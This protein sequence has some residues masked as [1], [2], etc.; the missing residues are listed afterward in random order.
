MWLGNMKCRV[1]RFVSGDDSPGSCSRCGAQLAPF[2]STGDE[3]SER[4]VKLAPVP[5][6]GAEPGER[7]R[8]E[9]ADGPSS[10]T[11]TTEEEGSLI[12]NARPLIN[13]SEITSECTSG[14]PPS[15][16]EKQEEEEEEGAS[17]PQGVT[18]PSDSSKTAPQCM[19]G[20][21]PKKS[22]KRKKKKNKG[23]KGPS[24]SGEQDSLPP[25]STAP[26]QMTELL[27]T[28]VIPQEIQTLGSEVAQ[29]GA[30]VLAGDSGGARESDGALGH[31]GKEAGSLE[32]VAEGSHGS[33]D[34][35]TPPKQ[36]STD[37]VA[38]PPPPSSAAPKEKVRGESTTVCGETVRRNVEG[39]SCSPGAGQ[40]PETRPDSQSS[41]S[42]KKL[43]STGE[44]GSVSSG[45]SPGTGVP[46][47]E[48]A[49]PGA[50]D[51]SQGAKTPPVVKSSQAGKDKQDARQKVS[52][53]TS[54]NEVTKEEKK[55]PSEKMHEVTEKASQTKGL[56]VALINTSEITSECTSGGPPSSTEKQEEEEEEGASL[57]QG[58]T[59]PSDSSKTAP[60]CMAGDSPKKSRKR[61]KKKNKGKKGP[62][63]SGEQDSLP[64]L[65]TA[66][67]QMTELLDTCVIPQEIQTLGSEVAQAGADVL[68]GD[69]GGAR[70]SDGAL[71]HLG[72]EAGSL[73]VVAEGSHGSVD[74]MTPP[75]QSSTDNV[76]A[77][78]PPSSA[79]PKEK[80]RGE[81]TTVCGETV[82]RNVEGGSCSPGA[83]Q[84]PETRPDSQSSGSSKKLAST[85]ERGSVSSGLSP[86]TGVPKSEPATPGAED[87][88]QGA[89]TPPVVKSSQAGKDKQDARQKVS[90]LT[91]KNEVTKEEKKTPSEKMHEVTEKRSQTKGPEVARKDGA[92]TVAGSCKEK[93][94]Q[95]NQKPVNKVKESSVSRSDGVTVYF[96]A[97][98]S[99][100]FKLNPE[101]HKVFIRAEGI[102]PY[103][104]WKDNICELNCTKYLGEHGYL[105]EG[106]VT[107]AK[108]HI[109]KCI[110]YKY[111]VTCGEGD[112]EFIYKHSVSSVYVN[113]C[114][115]IR[116]NILNNG[117]WHQ[118]DDIVCAKPSVM[119]NFWK[120]ISRNKNKEVVEGKIIAANIMLENIFS[121]LGT[122]SPNNLRNFFYQLNQF[123]VVT[124][125]PRVFDGGAVL[126]TE[127]NFGVQQV[128]D[129]LL[130]YIMKIALPFL[131]PE[132]AKALQEHLVIKSKVALGLTIMIVVDMLKLPALKSHLADLCSLLCLDKVSKQAILDDMHPITTAF[133]AVVSLKVY[134]TN[135]CQRCIDEQVDQWVWILP[136]LHFIA[137]PMQHD[138]LPMEE[139]TWAGLEGLPFAET[140]KKQD[141]GTL[142]QLMKEKKYL[143]ELD[144]TL[145]KSWISVLPLEGLAEFIKE[146]SSD[147]LVTLQ[148]V[149]YR[150]ENVD[151]LWNSPKLVESLLKT[152]LCTL[153]EKQYRALETCSWQ[154]CLTCCLKLHKRV[155]KYV[156]RGEWFMIPATSAMMI[157]KVAKLQ[158]TAVPRDAVQEVPVVEVFTEAM[159][160]VQTWFRNALNDKLL[161]EH[162]E[163]V[164]FSFC[165]ELWAWDAFVKISFPDE[166]FTERWKK[167]L[168]ADLE[169]R[170]QEEP[171]VNQILVYCCQHSQFAQLDSSLVCCFSNCATEA[172]TAACQTQSNLLEKLS[173]YN[174]GRFSQLVSTIIVKSWPIK[175]GQ[176]EDDFDEVLHHVLTWPDI[177]HIFSFNGTNTKLLEKLTDEAKNVMAIADSVF[178]SV[179]D[180]I[181][182]GCILVKHLEEIFQHEKQFICIWE[183]KHQQLLCENK[184]L[185]QSEL[186]ELLQRRQ[187]ELTL[188][189]K[190]QKAI[191]TFLNMCRKVQASV[192]VDVGELE[193]QHLEDLCS[194]RLNTVVNVGKR[195]LQTYYNLSPELKEFVRK[196]HSFKDSLI[197]QQFW[198]EAAQEAGK[199]YRSSEEEE[200]E[201]E[202]DDNIV[203]ALD[204][205]DVFCSLI[206][207]CFVSYERLYN[208]L[209]SGSLTLSAVDT[210]FQEFTNHPE[211][212]KTELNTICKLRPEED[213]HWVDQRFQQIQQY[214]EM[215]LTFDAA[216]I[217]ANVRE[218]LN[219]SGD[220]SILENLLDITEKLETYKTQKLDSI[221][222]ELMHAKRL[223]QGITVKRRGCLRELAQQKE[224]VCWVREALK[225][226]NELKVFVDLA[227]ISAGE[228][229]MDVDRVACF[230]DT[231]HGYSSLLYELRPESGF[232]DFMHCLG[233]LWRALDSDENL[234]KKL[235][236]SAQHLEWLKIVKESHGSV[237]LSSLSLAAAINSRGIYVLRAPADGQKVS[238]DNVVH[239]TLPRSSGDNEASRK[240]SLAELRELQNKLMLMSAKGEQGLEVE[241]F[242]EIFSNVQRLAQAFIDLYSAGNML[243]RSW[244]AH[245]YC[246][247]E[248]ESCVLIDF[249]LGLIPV[250]E[251]RG[252]MAAVLPGLCK[253]ME[254]FLES[255]KSFIYEKRF[256]HFYLNYYT[257]EQLVYLCTELG[258]GMPSQNALMM[259]SF[260][261]HNC[262]EQDVLR[263]S[264]S[265]VPPSSRKAISDFQVMLDG[266]KDL[267]AR[268]KC[269]W[270]CYMCNMGSF[271]PNC[272]DIDTL[273]GWLKNLA[274][275][276]REHVAREFPR[277]L[278][279]VGQPNLIVCP[280]SEVL[281]S[282]LA[283]YMNSPNQPLPTFD[284]VLL[285]TP[286]TT[287]EQVGLFL[288]RCLIP[289]S[290]GEKIYTMLYADELSYDVSCRAEELFQHLQRYNSTY[291]LII[292]CNCER[293][294]SYI[295]SVFSQ[296][297]VH[298]I[299]QRPLAEIQRY[300]QH[301]YRVA[302]PSSS[303]ASVFKGNM[304]VGIVSSKRA[305]VGK[306]LYVKRLHERL[307]EEQPDNTKL[308]KTIRLIEPEVDEDKVLTSLLPF[309][310]REHQTKPMI[311]H[312]DITSSVQSGVPE[313]LFKLL[314][315]QY[316]TDNNGNMWLRQKCHLYII[317][318]LE[319]SPVPKKAARHMSASQ[320]Y[321]FFDVFPKVTC[322]SPKEVL[323][324][325]T[326]GNQSG[327]VSDPGMDKEEFCSEAFQR[328]FQYLKRLDQGYNLD[329]FFYEVHSVEGSPAECLQHFLLHC[330]ITDPSWSELRNF[331]WF[332]NVQLRDCE[333]SVFCNPDFVQ[334][335]LQ[336][337]KNFV[338]TFMILMARDFA[339]PSLNIS[340][341]SSGRQS[342]NLENIAEE[343]LLPFRIRKKWESEPHPYL[344]F[345]ED[346]V[347]MTFIGFH[348][349]RNGSGG[350]DAINPLNGNIIKKNI[351]TSRLYKGLLLQ[352]VPFNIPFDQLPRHEKLEKLCMV[353]GIPWVIDPDETYELTT[354][355]VLKILAIEMRF[356]CN[357]PVVIMGETGC[358]KTRL[359]KFL[360]KL[361]RS[362]VEVENM[363]LVKVHGGTT[364]EMIYARIK[365]AEAL[366][367][368]N[369]EQHGLDTVLFFDE[370]NTTEAVSSIKEVLCDHTV[371]GKPLV[372]CS[373]LQIIAAC[374]PYRKH[375]PKMIQRLELAGLGY[376]VK[377]DETKDKLGSIP[378]RQLVYRVHALPPSMIPLVWDFG[379]LNNLTEKMYIQQI[380]QRVTE[381]VPMRQFEA[382]VITE[383][384]FASQQ[385]MRQRD[386][387]CSFVSLRDVERCMEVFKWFHKRSKLLLRELEK[388][389][390]EKRAPKSP[391]ERNNIIWS[392]VL[393]V[394]VCYH[395]SLEKKEGYRS[396]ISQVLPKPYDTQKKILE[397][398]SLMQDLFLSGVYLQDTI[399][400]NLALKENVFMMVICIELKIPLFLVGKPGSSKSLAK[401]IVADAM[402]GQAAHSD[403]FKDLKQIHLVSFQCSPLSTPE[404]IIGTFKHCA[405]FQ[406]GKNLEEYVSVV[407][408]DEI[409]LAEDSPKMPLKTLHP[410][411]E[412]GCI[413]DVPLPHKKVGFIGISN[414]AL[415]PAKMNR[416][417]F[418]SRGDPSKEELIESAK[419]ICCSARGALQKVE[420][421]F[422][423]FADAYENI[424]KAQGREFFGLRDYYS[425]IKMFFALAKSS[426]SE[427][428]P[429]DIATV[430][431]RNFGGKY[432]VNAL[433][434][435]TSRLPE[436]GE[437]HACDISRIELIR[438]N[439]Y[440]SGQ[441]G[442]C[443]YLL[444]LTE[445]YAALQILQQAF[446]T[447]RRQPEIIFGSSFPK[448]Q[449]YT[450]ICRN[451]NRVKVC[452]ETGQMVVL[453]NLQNLYESLYDALNQYYV[454]LAGQ[455]YVDL[456]LGTH[457]V[458]CR[459]H[460]NFR[461]IVIEEKD[462][463]YKHFPIPLINRLEK[464]YLDISTVLDKGQRET[465]KALKKWVHEFTAANTEEHF[466]SK[467]K[468]SPSDVF[469]G[470]HSNTCAS[471]VLQTTE[472]LKPVCPPSELMSC[473]KREAQ[474]ALLNCATPDSV[475][476]LCNSMGLF[477]ADSLANIYFKQQQHTS[478]ADFL[479]AHVHAGSGYQTVFTEVTTF[480]RLLTSADA[481]CLEREVQGKAQRPQILFLQQFDTEYS[482]LKSIR[483]FLDATSGNK[484]LI[485][486]TDFEDGSQNAQLIA[487]AKYTVVNEINKVDLGE[488]S[489]FVYFIMKLSRVEG[490]MSYVGFHGGLWQSVHIDDLRRSKDMI[491]DMTALQNVT[492][493]Q[494]FCE[495]SGK[496]KVAALP[497]NGEQE[498]NKVGV[499][500]PVPEAEHYEGEI[501]DTTVLLRTCVQSA[502]GMLR[503][504]NEDLSRSRKRI[505]IL[506]GLLSKEDG[507]KASFLRITKAR[508]SNLLKK[509]EENSLYPKNWV[510]REASN[511]SALQEAGTFR[512]TLWKRVQ[513]VITPFLALLIAVIDR[514]GNL[515][516]LVRPAAEWVT[517]L[518]MFIFSDTKLLTV[519]YGV[520]KNSSQPEIILV[521]NNMMVSADTGNEMP[522]SWRIKE[523][524][525]E[526]W[527]EA[528]YIQN[529]E[530]QAEK[531]VDIFQKTA[532]GKF[533]SALTGE[534]RQMLFQC[535]ITDF[536]VLTIGVSSLEELQCLRI[537]FLS[538]IEEWKA[539][540]PR[541]E[542]TVPSLPWVH[543]GYNQFKS[544]LQNFS[545]IL[546]VHPRVVDYL[547]NQEGYGIP[548]SEMVLDVLAAMIC[549]E[550]LESQVQT[551]H[552]KIW[553]QKVK[554]LRMPIEFLCKEKDLQRSGSWCH[555]LLKELKVCWNRVFSMSLFVEHVLFGINTL[556]PEFENLVKKYT[557][558]LAECFQHDSDMKTHPTFVAVMK[559][560]RQCKDEVSNRLYRYGVKSCPIC[561]GE[562]K[563]PVCLPC[564]HVFCQKCI[565]MWLVP[566]QM[567]CPYCRVAVEDVHLNVSVE[568][569]DAIARNA[570]FRQRCNNFFI[571]VVTTM[572]FKDNEPPEAEVIQE[573]LNLLF[574]H[575]SLLTGSDHPTI[576]T[577]FLSPF[578]DEVD[579]IPIIRS[580]ML[581][582]LLKYSFNEVKND[583]QRYLSQVEH[584]QILEKNDKKEL[585]LLFV[586]CLEDSMCEKSEGSIGY[587]YINY[588]PGDRSFPENY[589][590]KNNQETPQESSVEYL[591][592]VAKVRLYLSKAAELVFD[593]HEPTEQD[594][595]E[596]KQRYL[597]NVRVFCSLA[598][599]NWHCVYLVRK[600]AS[601]YGMEF[602]QKL[603]T[604]AQFNWVF[605]VEILQQI[606]N[607]RSNHID[608]YL[609]C[610]K[611]YRVLRDA[612]GKAMIE[613]KTEGLLE[614]EKASSSSPVVQSVH[615][616]LA[617]FRELT[618]LYGV[619]D[620]SLHPKQQQ[621]DVMTKFIQNSEVL[622]SPD[623]QHFAASLVMNALP[624]LTVDPQSFSH[625][626][627]LIEM[628]V[629]TTAV[630]L[631][632]QNPVL[633]PLRN[634]AFHPHTM[635][636]SFLPTMPEDIMAQA[637][638]WEGVATLR[639]Y[640]CPN[641]HPCTV[642]ECGLP[643]ETSHCPDC[644]AQVGGQL[645]KPLR[646]FQEFRSNEDRT[647]TGHILGDVQHRKTMGVSDRAMSPVVFVL[648]RLLTHLTML[649]GATKDPQSLQRIIKP[650]V[651]NSV[652][653]LQQHIREDLAQLTK[654]LGKSVDE[655]IT[656]LHLVLSSLLKNTHQHPGQWPV[657]FDNV[658]STK[659]KR[660]KWE[661]VVANTIIV[662]ELEDLDKKILKLNRQIQEDERISSNPIVKIVY[663][664]P[665]TF[666][667]QLP[668]DSHI[669]HSK[670]WSCRKRISVEN[671]GHVVQQK[672]AKDTVPLLWKFLQ[673]E[674]ELRLV[675]FLPEILALQ[676][677][678]VRRFQNTAAVKQ[679]SI[680]DFLKEPLSDVMRDLLQRRVNVFLSVWNKLRSSLDTNG[681]IKLPKGYCDADLTLDSKLEVLLPRRQG[682]G[683]CSTALA[684]YL[685]SLHNDFIHSVNKHIKEDDRYFISPS[686]V[687]DLHLISYELER[688]LI[689]LILSNCQYSMEKGGETLQDFDLERIQQQVISKFLQGKPLITLKGI[690]TLVYRHDRNY[691]QMFSDV[692][693]KLD[694]S[695]LPS[696]V[697]N[698][699]SGELQSYS[700]VCDALSITE[701]TLG[702]LAMAGEN[703]EMLLT[704]YIENVLQMGDQTNPHVLQALRRCH[705]KHNIA[706]WQ[707]L[708][709]RKSEQLLRLKRDPFVDINTAYKAELSPEIAKLLN[710]FLVHSRLETFLQELH[711]MIVLKLRR[712]QAVDE[713]RPIW[714]LKES[715]IPYL[716]AKD[717]E[718]AT[719]LQEL[720]PDEILLCHAIATWKAAVLFKREHRE[721]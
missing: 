696:S 321:N 532:L 84:L 622:N 4:E 120:M 523:Y 455:K 590:P 272:L 531:F 8:G 717:S 108:E 503:D 413:D 460:P 153:D 420:Q 425:L 396:A 567:H 400:R 719:E 453:L 287:A 671:L 26:A 690:P 270:E 614:A 611:N 595:V 718:L 441:D 277:D 488:V 505:K 666:L 213:R 591:Q 209:R 240:Y 638:A 689:P 337:F 232:K 573:L 586:N 291:R 23:K 534:E 645:H 278:L 602:A 593:L 546:A 158:P 497:V 648:I 196:M 646:G 517:N 261:K 427:P 293:E 210:I 539:T 435:F 601:Q 301:H 13:T 286:Q 130:N 625:S 506:L 385:Y 143:M 336:G 230:H 103:V 562:P 87:R 344:F 699:I 604:E 373:G 357:I 512:H 644:G 509:Q 522:F 693:N 98:L 564:Y 575:R 518:W 686:E 600:I 82:R 252:D 300:L 22:R 688:D 449:E 649:L 382:E 244:L 249:S 658:L 308:L 260:L 171:P 127:L 526:M 581:K 684:S 290:R 437:I 178:I 96:H 190:D 136:L 704:D 164:T 613:C 381:H 139:D 125:E 438:Q 429:Q 392:L 28:C 94:Q 379:Q 351:M 417:I 387:E 313:F 399:A 225:G 465:V 653:F 289:C 603:V 672:N 401:T 340:D 643:M 578:N 535:Y 269:I 7:V 426:K 101:T 352:R 683:L 166:Q 403:L 165:W 395:A 566:A 250:L 19:A 93:K 85:G 162:P 45:L 197:F 80:V 160:H 333:A 467:Q 324:M 104:D 656:I 475:I 124:V 663:G 107:L 97:V 536:I 208:D 174:M 135:L 115:L 356:R 47:S 202:E 247:P 652:S 707:L 670:M 214:H 677:D 161:K 721:S 343:D 416:G 201:E 463:V 434:I 500:T 92:S 687:A 86:G 233:K 360:C 280:R 364:A 471:V 147:L 312:F 16:T 111:W 389:L 303:A 114:L 118:Y 605:P 711:E 432:D 332:L 347:S 439:I 713:F 198:E 570:L 30:D 423:H 641:G 520:G 159:R 616:L 491:S 545:R 451:I 706:L 548:Q 292:L 182:K 338:V 317:E 194:K 701:I 354:D 204:L 469:V 151:L 152:L 2:A 138:H 353:L 167:T 189:R 265:E 405:R 540:S 267:A 563:D 386:D 137:A 585:Y 116:G 510:L 588:L 368:T 691:E 550:E 78:P 629:H 371:Q 390:A 521:Q 307:Q 623:L 705:L 406:E 170:V 369:K 637:R 281:T 279:S 294:H 65:S 583:V 163:H 91:S 703:A 620:S 442:D 592:A 156:K 554:N 63:S 183:I 302:Q 553:L 618:A 461:L 142:L 10:T 141:T 549:A 342:S 530:D 552:P 219:L 363:K 551:A 106:T 105:I 326:L 295:P 316:L 397:E 640:T 235:H 542:E 148:G 558:H 185:L 398:I 450:Q 49:T 52:C 17:L 186:K 655:T 412:D 126:W 490:G 179:T 305:G 571:D 61:E 443:R 634:L 66:P 102:S 431:L 367:K 218:I 310:K 609:A 50:E 211:D 154:S 422:C 123:Y 188:L 436:K 698:M 32:V 212:I 715:L 73:E 176:P 572:C 67:A 468:Y 383:V 345:N 582:L 81:S 177:K 199:D 113:R 284:E 11:E 493:S 507:L 44:R 95:R 335:T 306:S 665:V 674:T 516:L 411:L 409:G 489:V 669:H 238:L 18:A 662:P 157:S 694:Q 110:P 418:V 374:N 231:V 323:E 627:A 328:P 149:S 660:N 175:N 424:C 223:L 361:R 146:F 502:V 659:E 330:G 9:G 318:I 327:D 577:K 271:L 444:V 37:N 667:S 195:P 527:L 430:V 339:T 27:D 624:S 504:Q 720:F 140:R 268:L 482:F 365:E 155:C 519:P 494:I 129:L 458:K 297:K 229:D 617:I 36:S 421:Y 257:A 498:E 74:V 325:E 561:L 407:V 221:S 574:V 377:A 256:Q 547:I 263:A 454:Y 557:L 668:K 712:V 25:L 200:E 529:T 380:V 414:W 206:S 311:F 495:D 594:Q 559:V 217:I 483:D 62:S 394:G 452:M 191:G 447:A 51:R 79:A 633:Q 362:C 132:D 275:W 334:D 709:T 299:P 226:T 90:C 38:A 258:Q 215:H 34:V 75:K 370:A 254:S 650:P 285:C 5:D 576:Y 14:G 599:N 248:K 496:T 100:D 241:K 33:V 68:A 131:A 59:A 555:Q 642:G 476:R 391:V 349:Q 273:G 473:V 372:S 679:G 259:L 88:S 480:S 661:E 560:L 378:L 543:L 3:D 485:I 227:S 685:I 350:V 402:Q 484:V 315:L 20:D 597:A 296:Y 172:V 538:C 40:L 251:G 428:T 680:R 481:V 445:N 565:R 664:D 70:E 134:L 237:E 470:Y 606:Q 21:S 657:R 35:M 636:H 243:F 584:S 54:K 6:T 309:L 117:E 632:G 283:V 459:V 628:A 203:P 224:F 524:L 234:P 245:V 626:G 541:R 714:S 329:T 24:S 77:P 675:K 621:T 384:L 514:N 144:K 511:L 515:E 239:F 446:F 60:Q 341:Q 508:L 486:Q 39:G 355:N 466:I 264:R 615:L 716:D 192:K 69:S 569:R 228:N 121:I 556:M 282:A 266:G 99:K 525:D 702:F 31:L 314:V 610:G 635:E 682:L 128:N 222:P 122:W 492:I 708:S 288:R 533:I 462:V 710:T 448:D 83:G 46:K 41:G 393:A 359:I 58:V 388:Y 639:W 184:E 274:S 255:W 205:S 64:P 109:N 544:R 404:G 276:E 220:F 119:R 1:C 236:A 72:K 647:Q 528:Q 168:L 366:A 53:L 346:R 262:T 410:L 598:K 322:K 57:P 76:A 676:R 464:H 150:L 678:L 681:E 499:E 631:C 375:T 433:E 304:C 112:Y 207:P 169:R 181:Q 474:L 216:K 478:F 537:A 242:S 607:S 298:M 651:H 457:R 477:M 42:S 608:R 589:L 48:P 12:E 358:G 440:S 253:T 501:L 695:P 630:L 587:E 568:L 133:E 29:A 579:E 456:G 15:S 673:K 173:S 193:L 408:L 654:I 348:F 71:G 479:R 619:S 145:V 320:K 596:E 56:G 472:R 55:T 89:K 331:A 612:V 513:N 187:K 700:D 43:A 487:S 419:G 415:D 376:R 319:V 180:D 580:V 697:M 246:S 692:R